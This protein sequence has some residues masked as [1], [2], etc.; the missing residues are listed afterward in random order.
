MTT[1]TRYILSAPFKF[2]GTMWQPGKVILSNVH[3]V[4]LLIKHGAQLQPDTSNPAVEN[5]KRLGANGQLLQREALAYEGVVSRETTFVNTVEQ[6]KACAHL[7]TDGSTVFVNSLKRSF[8]WCLGSSITPDG[9]IVIADDASTGVFVSRETVA[10]YWTDQTTWFISAIG[11]DE[12][13]GTEALPIATVKEWYTRTGG[14]FRDGTVLTLVPGETNEWTE[15]IEGVV[16][17]EYVEAVLHIKGELRTEETIEDVVIAD[18]TTATN[19]AA[20]ITLVDQDWSTYV[21]KLLATETGKYAFAFGESTDDLF[22]AYWFQPN[23][24][25]VGTPT[26]A[27]TVLVKSLTLIPSLSLR[28]MNSDFEVKYSNMHVETQYAYEGQTFECCQLDN[29]HQLTGNNNTNVNSC[30]INTS[31]ELL[32]SRM[33]LTNTIVAASTIR[34]SYLSIDRS[35]FLGNVQVYKSNVDLTNACW[36]FGITGACWQLKQGAYADFSGGALAGVN[37]DIVI[38]L[39]HGSKCLVPASG[40]Y[41]S[42]DTSDFTIEA[43]TSMVPALAGGETEVPAAAPCSTWA[44]LAAA[45]FSGGV[46]HYKTGASIEQV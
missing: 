32:N 42:G 22:T 31:F 8:Q 30:C 39:S 13:P 45:P 12:N 7:L 44:E 19:T 6:M 34:N 26:T 46:M 40:A 36:M 24:G 33:T 21:G 27:T 25:V 10:K 35:Y 18:A 5:V 38:A 23:T 29:Y 9:L 28:P 20:K 1:T 11:D 17:G 4:P 41:L 15:S 16:T 37:V 14:Q 3:N 2:F 43:Q